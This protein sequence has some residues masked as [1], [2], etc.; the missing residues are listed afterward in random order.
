MVRIELATRELL[1]Q[2]GS[3]YLIC[4]YDGGVSEADTVLVAY[5]G[6]ELAGAVR[7]C[8]G[9]GV[10]VLRGMQVLLRFQR[11]GIG[12]RLLAACVPHFGPHPAFCLPWAHLEAFYAT[13]G[14][15]RITPAA[16]PGF[17]SQRYSSYVARGLN[18]IVMKRSL[19]NSVV[20]AE[21][22]VGRAHGWT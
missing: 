14:F 6:T 12:S 16:A 5:D 15:A 18:V 7:L 1:S 17:L 2:I 10:I 22:P 21:A 3:F 8:P 9:S 4:G 20:N 11:Q 19:P 13:V